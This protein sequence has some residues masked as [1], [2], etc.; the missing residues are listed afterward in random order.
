MSRTRLGVGSAIRVITHP[1]PVYAA[2]YFILTII[3]MAGLILLLS[4]EFMAFAVIIVYAGAILVTYLFV[5]MAFP[6]V[7]A[8]LVGQ[9]Q[10]ATLF[11]A[12]FS[13]VLVL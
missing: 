8:I 3:A 7:N 6:V 9:E 10:W 5:I 4:A 12:N 1:H 13:L 11:V 2:L